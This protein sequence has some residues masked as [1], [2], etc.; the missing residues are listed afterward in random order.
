MMQS[1]VWAGVSSE[2]LATNYSSLGKTS[3][4]RSFFTLR[5]R[6]QCG[7]MEANKGQAAGV[8]VRSLLCKRQGLE[9]RR[10]SRSCITETAETGV[11]S[12]TTTEEEGVVT[13]PAMKRQGARVRT[14]VCEKQS[15]YERNR[16]VPTYNQRVRHTHARREREAAVASRIR[17]GK[18]QRL[19]CPAQ[20][21]LRVRIGVPRRNI[22]Q[23]SSNANVYPRRKVNNHPNAT[24]LLRVKLGPE[25]VRR[26]EFLSRLGQI[27]PPRQPLQM[28][29]ARGTTSRHKKCKKEKW[30][31]TTHHEGASAAR[32]K[33]QESTGSSSPPGSNLWVGR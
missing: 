11:H 13:D 20:N 9:A 25:T 14:Y 21:A 28:P 7:L 1:D 2:T 3:E 24:D 32:K 26:K 29:A 22:A 19:S 27:A 30:V 12:S 17:R 8:S 5:K 4:I 23:Q 18:T 15:I 6:G 10:R 31:G 16:D 33:K